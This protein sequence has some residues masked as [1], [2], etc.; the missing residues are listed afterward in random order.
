MKLSKEKLYKLWAL[1]LVMMLFMHFASIG[2]YAIGDY[3]D[4]PTADIT[5]YTFDQICSKGV[6]F[7]DDIEKMKEGS[8]IQKGIYLNFKSAQEY[9]KWLTKAK[10]W[11]SNSGKGGTTFK[12]APNWSATKDQVGM[13]PTN[14]SGSGINRW[15]DSQQ[16][17]FWAQ[18]NTLTT[19]FNSI[20]TRN[21]TSS[22]TKDVF[23]NNFDPTNAVTLSFMAM[24]TSVCNTAFSIAA[25]LLMMLFLVQTGFD[26]LYMVIPALQPILAPANSNSSHGGGAGVAKSGKFSL[27]F[28]VV[29]NEAVDAA[30]KSASGSV[31]GSGSGSLLET[32]IFLKYIIARAPLFLLAASY[33]V[34]VTTGIWPRLVSWLASLVA[35][36]F[37]AVL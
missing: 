13:E 32:N 6:K 31:G 9:T 30:N 35:S 29:S 22:L 17:T 27:K 8:A 15:D 7:T 33:V 5:A 12:A 23:G 25:K 10:I 28:N 3:K 1:S 4:L 19:K 36:V 18:Y 24:F 20:E 37:N 14:T 34:L 26:C 2:A 16:A 11:I 21:A